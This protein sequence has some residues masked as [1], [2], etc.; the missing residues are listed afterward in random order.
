MPINLSGKYGISREETTVANLAVASMHR[1]SFSVL[2]F[3]SLLI[4]I[5]TLKSSPCI[6]NVYLQ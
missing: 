1:W 5:L 2:R 4:L 3:S 6:A